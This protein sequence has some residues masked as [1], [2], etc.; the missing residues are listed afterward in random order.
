MEFKFCPLQVEI[1]A[2]SVV[3]CANV[4]LDNGLIPRVEKSEHALNCASQALPVVVVIES[5]G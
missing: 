5:R 3:Y 2:L 1:V 4:A